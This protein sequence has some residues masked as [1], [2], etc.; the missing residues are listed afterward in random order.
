MTNSWYDN[1]IFY[2]LHGNGP[3]NLD[4]K[5]HIELRL[6][7]ESFQLIN[8]ILFRKKIDG[9]FLR[10]LEKEESERVLAELHSGDIEGHFGGDKNSHKVLRT[11]HY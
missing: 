2:L 10:C 4:T 8:D 1:I 5:N 6:R 11:C 3:C 7:S 9:V